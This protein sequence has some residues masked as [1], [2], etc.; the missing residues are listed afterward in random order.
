MP[1]DTS[2][3]EMRDCLHEEIAQ[4]IGPLNDLYRLPDS[5]FNDDNFHTVLT[6]F[7]MLMLRLYYAPE[8]RSGMSREAV[9]TLLPALLQRENPGGGPVGAIGPASPTDAWSRAI[10][11]A[12]GPSSPVRQ[13]R[14]AADQALAIASRA[15]WADCRRAFSHFAVGRLALADDGERALNELTQAA[16]YYQSL[17]GTEIHLAHVDMQIAAYALSTGQASMALELANRN[18]IPVSRAE[19]AALLA[20]LLMIKSEALELLDRPAEAKAVRLDS[21][22]WARYSFG[23]DEQVRARM[24]GSPCCRRDVEG[25]LRN[26]RDRRAGAGRCLWRLSRPKTPRQPAGHGAICRRLCGGL[27]GCGPV[28]DRSD[29]AFAL[30]RCSCPSSKTFAAPASR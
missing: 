28:P 20:T 12:L 13:R 18:L 8:L 16:R 27:C 25:P 30:G 11:T 10:E 29:R 9:A 3:Q 17:P 26:D 6:G 15:G 24:S 14:A 2:P 1:N 23:S 22:G 5:V 19:N 7:D 21:L 4:A